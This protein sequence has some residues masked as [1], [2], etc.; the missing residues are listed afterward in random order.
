[1]EPNCMCD[2]CNGEYV[3]DDGHF[4]STAMG[5]V[6]FCWGCEEEIAEEE[7]MDWENDDPMSYREE[8]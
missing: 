7:D 3:E 2:S 4:V 6:F 5:P 1:M 8:F